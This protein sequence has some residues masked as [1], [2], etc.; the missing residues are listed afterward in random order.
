LPTG[1]VQ[2]DRITKKVG[3]DGLEREEG[4]PNYLTLWHSPSK[5]MPL[6][7]KG[8]NTSILITKKQISHNTKTNNT[9]RQQQASCCYTL[10]STRWWYF[11]TK[12]KL[13]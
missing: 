7:T 3:I 5:L 10:M 12:G 2:E 1:Q 11:L 9:S 8:H 13:L 6:R 4:E